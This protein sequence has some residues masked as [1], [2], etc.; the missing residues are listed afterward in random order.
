[1]QR[2]LRR[3]T[4]KKLPRNLFELHAVQCIQSVYCSPS[5]NRKKEGERMGSIFDSVSKLAGGLMGGQSGECA[6]DHAAVA[7]GL[8]QELSGTGV[9]NLIQTLQ[10]N[11]AGSM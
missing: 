7:G 6:P 4:R 5:T 11:G 1:M 8:V 3:H 9:G 10:Q 2:K